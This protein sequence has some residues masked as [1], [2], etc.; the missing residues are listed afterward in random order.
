MLVAIL[1]MMEMEIQLTKS[2]LAGINENPACRRVFF[3]QKI[4]NMLAICILSNPDYKYLLV[5]IPDYFFAV[6]LPI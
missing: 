5:Q 1:L 4:S 3:D 2:V 6:L